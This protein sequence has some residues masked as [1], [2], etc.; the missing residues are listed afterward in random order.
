MKPSTKK[1]SNSTAA[2]SLKVGL[3]LDDGLDKPDGVQQYILAIGAW[4]QSQGHRVHYIVGETKRTDIPNVH[5]MS[6]NIRVTSNGNRMSIPLPTS[7]RRLRKFLTEQQFD[8]LHVQV[9]FSPLMAG[10]L[11]RAAQPS[12]GVVGTFHILPNSRFITIGTRL[13]GLYLRRTLRRFDVQLSV[14]S[15]AQHFAA[16][17]FGSNSRVLPNVIDYPRFNRAQPF[18]RYNDDVLTVLFLGR[19]VPRKGSLTLIEAVARLRQRN[20]LP[21]FRV[22][23]CG[24]GPL[25]ARV[26]ARIAEYGLA[27]CVEMAGFVNEIDKPHYY[28]S[29]DIAVFPSSGGESFGIVLLE[30]MASGKAAVL[31]GDNPG[32]RTVMESQPSLLFNPHDPQELADKIAELLT[33]NALRDRE[34]YWGELYTKDFD[35]AT[36]GQKLLGVYQ[37]ALHKRRPQ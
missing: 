18:D 6:R 4:L 29:A 26:R 10:R 17:T 3:V 12:T 22:V 31:A 19:L 32:Y 1:L 24:K 2:K 13:L 15:A 25:E 34:R 30:A 8:I 35:V 37:E 5:S 27:D 33:D 28:A 23:L 9:P 20:D 21:P 36:V 11:V 14:S 16:Q 7:R